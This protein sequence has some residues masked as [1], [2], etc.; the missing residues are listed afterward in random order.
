M[1]LRHHARHRRSALN[2]S[3]NDL[4]LHVIQLGIEKNVETSMAA[5]DRFYKNNNNNVLMDIILLPP[6]PATA[7]Q[8]W[9]RYR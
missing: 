6:S 2:S 3:P 1:S 7:S 4:I 8:S 9:L 5:G